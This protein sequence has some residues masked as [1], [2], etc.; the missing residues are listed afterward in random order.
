MTIEG[1]SESSGNSRSR[2]LAIM[3]YKESSEDARYRDQLLFTSFYLSLIFLGISGGVVIDIFQQTLNPVLLFAVSTFALV[4][5][6]I[7]F[8]WSYSVKAARNKAWSRRR[9]IEEN[10]LE[11]FLNQRITNRVQRRWEGN[12]ASLVIGYTLL[13]VIIWAI[14]AI[15]SILQIVSVV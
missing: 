1:D 2:E 10:E 6:F 9:E 15:Y 7:L 12:Q 8:S 4:A 3:E 14:L 11:L 13:M 5:F